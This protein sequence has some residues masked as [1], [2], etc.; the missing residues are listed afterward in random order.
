MYFAHYEFFLIITII[1]III[2]IIYFFNKIVITILLGSL[3]F[4]TKT[5]HDNYLQ[6]KTIY[7]NN[8]IKIVEKG[9]KM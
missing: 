4:F 2:I 9:G 6:H 7:N 5:L 8:G 3:K 1:I